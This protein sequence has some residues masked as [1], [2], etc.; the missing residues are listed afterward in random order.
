MRTPGYAGVTF[1]SKMHCHNATFQKWI[2]SDIY[3]TN[4]LRIDNYTFA[5]NDE[6]GQYY[7]LEC[8]VNNNSN[9]TQSPTIATSHPTES[10]TITPHPPIDYPVR[11]ILG[12]YILIC[13]YIDKYMFV[14]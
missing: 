5:R 14:Y 3:G 6:C 7:L 4:L 1:R 13:V 2:Y 11:D 12:N 8:N 9:T 10:P